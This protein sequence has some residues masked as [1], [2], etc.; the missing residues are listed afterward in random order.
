MI[1]FTRCDIKVSDTFSLAALNWQIEPGQT[2]VVVGPNGSGKSALGAALTGEFPVTRGDFRSESRVAVVSLEEQSRLIQ[3]ERQRDESDLTDV[4]DDGTPVHE[5]L[6][7][8][9]QDPALLEQLIDSLG[10]GPLLERGFRKL[11]TG[12]SRKVLLIRALTSQPEVLVL[13]EPFAG[14]DM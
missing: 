14:L 1:R 3:R 9:L 13:D 11:S 5:M 2:W 6:S 10:M 7:E 8:M 12:E 4:V